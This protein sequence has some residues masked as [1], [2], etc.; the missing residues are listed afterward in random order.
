MLADKIQTGQLIIDLRLRKVW[1]DDTALDVSGLTFTMLRALV[2]ADNQVLSNDAL[3]AAVWKNKV[4][5]DETVAQRISLLRK[6]LGGE[7]NTYIE[8]V[9]GEGY[10]WVQSVSA[11]PLDTS[12]NTSTHYSN[13]KKRLIV[14]MVAFLIV[15][16]LIGI[17]QIIDSPVATVERR[18]SAID[19]DTLILN[20]A[21][22]YA[23][24]FNARDNANAIQ[25]YRQ[26]LQTHPDDIRAI[27]GLTQ[28]LLHAVSK[29]GGA[30]ELLVDAG[31]YS[32]DL[33]NQNPHEPYHIWLRGFY[34]DVQ[35]N[36]TDAIA[37]YE[38]GVVA[39]PDSNELK[40][41]LAHL[42]VQKGRLYDALV[43]NDET[44]GS[45]QHYQFL[46][47]AQI[48]RL[49]GLKK[50]ALDSFH[51][52]YRLSPD[53]AF[54]NIAL[55]QQYIVDGQLDMAQSVID[56]LHQARIVTAGTKQVEAII[57]L[58]QDKRLPA[59]DAI[60]QAMQLKPGSVYAEAWGDWMQREADTQSG[61][62][63][64]STINSVLEKPWGPE[65]AIEQLNQWPNIW[66]MKAIKAQANA[67]SEQALHYLKLAVSQG[68][69]DHQWLETI[70]PFASLR[71]NPE[72]VALIALA[73]QKAALEKRKIE[74]YLS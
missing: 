64:D 42:Y 5:S 68:Y 43:L 48:Y 47:T 3:V 24:H 69:L 46:Q 70:P 8:S 60:K 36:I 63:A 62:I 18:E 45:E 9:R 2:L 12:G 32:E 67:R 59:N 38:K 6:S 28:A 19:V 22:K 52:A 4:V 35:G 29:F 21:D 66:V 51:L 49:A 26:Y 17:S 15:A 41:A 74:K 61:A 25:L 31:T 72:W 44:K 65:A 10:R 57:L 37:W 33:I 56:Q 23:S 58:M 39:A 73:K 13:T 50:Q 1:C 54:T 40:G 11:V 14:G 27:R 16:V 34:F 55:A 71:G 30:V 20:R 7:K 53:D